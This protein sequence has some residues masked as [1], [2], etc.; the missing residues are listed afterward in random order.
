MVKYNKRVGHIIMCSPDFRWMEKTVFEAFAD[1]EELEEWTL[2]EY[3]A[4]LLD[5]NEYATGSML[6]HNGIPYFEYDFYDSD[7]QETYH[8]TLFMYR[9]DSAFC[10]VQ[11]TTYK[12]A[13][14]RYAEKIKGFAESVQFAE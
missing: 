4:L 7:T 2:E 3:S 1:F 6:Y 10:V 12:S 5:S 11:F 9:S 8:H 14:G 13:A